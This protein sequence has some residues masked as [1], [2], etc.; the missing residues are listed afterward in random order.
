MF[1]ALVRPPGMTELTTRDDEPTELV[2]ATRVE[3]EAWIQLVEHADR[4]A[5]AAAGLTAVALDRTTA[6]RCRAGGPLFNRAYGAAADPRLLAALRT[7]YE[8]AGVPLY[9][10][11]IEDVDR[12]RDAAAAEAGLVPYRRAMLELVHTGPAAAPACALDVGLAIA[13]EVRRAAEIYCAAFDADRVLAPVLASLFGHPCWQF[14]VAR[15]GGEPVAVGVLHVQGGAAYLMGGATLPRFRSRGAQSALIAARVARAHELGCRVVA[16][17]TGE[18]VAGDRQHSHHNMVR[19]GFA[20][21][22]RAV[23]FAPPGIV[24]THGRRA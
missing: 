15:S 4:H 14:V 1:R 24:W 7:H 21:V 11:E 6:V 20:V 18:A 5:V 8:G 3:R 12:A 23:S 9:F 19:N 17:R 13:D 2:S 16:A 10:I 22:G